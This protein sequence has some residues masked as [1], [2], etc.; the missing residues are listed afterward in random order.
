MQLSTRES[1]DQEI[2][3]ALHRKILKR[4]HNDPD[5]IVINELG[6]AHGRHRIDIAVLNGFIHGY[7]IKSSKDTLA[8]LP[9]Q[10][11]EY[12]RSLEKISIVSAPNHIDALM[13]TAPNWCGLVLAEKGS[14]GAIHFSTIRSPKLNPAVEFSA[15]AHLLWRKEAIVLLNKL[16]ANKNELKGSKRKLYENLS[17]LISHRELSGYI[18]NFFMRRNNWRVDLQLS[19]YDGSL[20]PASM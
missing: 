5:V 8:R 2:R 3:N 16:G 4:Y 11:A 6:L 13:E 9:Q 14:K 7:E 1:S 10:F 20:L 12:R 15:M 17:E 18:K 19:Q